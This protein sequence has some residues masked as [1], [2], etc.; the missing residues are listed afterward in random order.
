MFDTVI[1]GAGT[2]GC[3]LA[4]RLSADPSRKVLLLEAGGQPPLASDIP[5]DWLTMMNSEVDWG[6]Y[7]VP[8]EGCRGRRIFWP[9]GKMIGGS[10]SIN[11]MIYIRGLPSDFDAWEALG[12]LGWG[13]RD[14]LPLFRKSENNQVHR[15]AYHGAEGELFIDD[16]PYVDAVEKT[17]LESVSKLYPRRADFN[18][19]VQEGVGFYQFNIRNGERFGASKAFLTPVLDRPNL[20][21]KTGVAITRLVLDGAR[22]VGVDYIEK[23]RSASVTAG[24]TIMTAGA[25]GSAQLLLLSGIGPAGELAEVGIA[26][27][28]DLPGV[29]KNLQDHINLP[30]TFHLKEKAGIGAMTADELAAG[31]AE[32][33]TSRTGIRTSPWVAGG[34]FVRSAENV[35]E[36]DLQLYIGATGHRDHVRYLSSRPGLSLHTTLQRPNSLGTLKLRSDNPLDYP[37]IDP[38]YFASDES[39]VDLATL[40]E[41]VKISRRIAATDPLA[42]L[43][44]KEITPSAEARTDA[45]IADYVRGHC[46]TLYHAA[47]TC[48]MGTDALAVVDPASMKV[49][50]VEGLRVADAS[51]FPKMISGNTNAA[52]LMI[53]EKAALTIT[54]A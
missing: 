45:E 13:W 7:T 46:T 22:V 47:G 53:A 44:D 26:T 31:L 18:G 17:W 15:D 2:A 30:V 19:A 37:A 32:W 38:R 49:H 34:G 4:N 51:V 5:S 10:A 48:K 36:P 3:V 14:V 20:T 43:I 42:S 21:V 33:Q 27:A 23:G 8:Q 6:Y 54:G 25:I 24:E 28:V 29:G 40:V 39:G 1:V 9:R 16:V 50:G 35:A 52:T 11:A 41:G 12:C